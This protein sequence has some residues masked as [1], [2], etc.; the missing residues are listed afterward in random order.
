[1]K[2]VFVKKMKRDIFSKQPEFM[3][4][5]EFKER[6]FISDKIVLK[7]AKRILAFIS[8]YHKI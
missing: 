6:I 3:T 1:M 2:S 5:D 7:E 8:L 4:M